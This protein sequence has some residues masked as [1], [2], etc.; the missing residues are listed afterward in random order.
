[1]YPGIHGA[2]GQAVYNR[3]ITGNVDYMVII[4]FKKPEYVYPVITVLSAIAGL[5][6]L[7]FI[8]LIFDT[9][10]VNNIIVLF[11]IYLQ[12]FTTITEKDG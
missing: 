5:N 2:S 9:L 1:M 8:G 12:E 3:V 10:M 6:L 7:G 11:G 4:T